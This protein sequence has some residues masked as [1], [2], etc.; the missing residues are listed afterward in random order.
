MH[1]TVIQRVTGILIMLFSLTLIPPMLVG[2]IYQETELEAFVDSY[3]ILLA[4]GFVLWLP[5]K[6]VKKDLRLR[7]GFVV[8]VVSGWC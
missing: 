7:D 3:F 1:L 8:V 2:L 6:N 5:V 4:L